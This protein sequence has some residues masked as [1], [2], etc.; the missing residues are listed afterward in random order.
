M[1]AA[2]TDATHRVAVCGLWHLGSTAAAGLLT[3]G[4]AVVAYDPQEHLRAGAAAA[5]PPTGEPG[6]GEVLRRGL[7]EGRLRV[8]DALAEWARNALCV[9]AY[10]SAVDADG[11]VDDARLAQAVAA[12]ARHA[13]AGATLA[14]LSQ[15]PAHTHVRWRRTLLAH[16]PDVNLV[17]IPENLRLGRAMD[18]FVAPAR[19][20]VGAE[21]RCTA[22]R[23]AR[24]LFPRATPAYVTLTEAELVKHAT[25]AYLG[26]C[27]S[28]GNELGWLAAHLGADPQVVARLLK[29]DPR[30]ADAAPLLPGAA[31]SG[32]TLRRDLVALSRIGAKWGRPEFFDTVLTVNDRHAA[33]PLD[34]LGAELGNLKDRRIAVAG[35]T[36]K[37]GTATLRDSLPLRL[38]RTLLTDGAEV[39]A[40]DP[41]AEDLPDDVGARRA[42][43]LADAVRGAD[44]LLVAAALPEL[45]GADWA[46]L[47]P[48]ARLVVDG[49]GALDPAALS[50]A[51]WRCLGLHPRWQEVTGAHA[52]P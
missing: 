15:V 45:D 3:H 8:A 32:A 46:G 23:T 26:M 49:C 12:F 21:E 10:D 22:E 36:Y 14:V 11:G 34:L 38:V 42:A 48:A 41:V 50:A 9:L 4:R 25:N 20:V 18:D 33:F 7:R 37:P 13:P 43:T 28:F 5:T 19:L 6:V 52:A 39:V 29:A 2:V 27:V 24:S 16:R 1:A 40:Y 44:A 17:H 51:G 31:F 30:V 47:R 35:L